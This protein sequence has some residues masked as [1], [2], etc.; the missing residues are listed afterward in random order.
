MNS[1]LI[2]KLLDIQ[3]MKWHILECHSSCWLSN[4]F[5]TTNWSFYLLHNVLLKHHHD[6]ASWAHSWWLHQII[7]ISCSCDKIV[8]WNQTFTDCHQCLN[9]CSYS[10]ISSLVASLLLEHQ[11]SARDEQVQERIIA[12][13]YVL[14]CCQS[15]SESMHV[16]WTVC[17][18]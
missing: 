2:L 16:K 18:Q 3:Y 13:Y 11:C 15:L 6:A 5:W 1:V 4:T 14:F 10:V 17:N 7:C 12:S 8:Q 9:D